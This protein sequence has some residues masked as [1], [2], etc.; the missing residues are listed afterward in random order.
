MLLISVVAGEYGR[1]FETRYLLNGLQTQSQR[2]FALL[3]AA[4]LEA[5]IAA[6]RPMLETVVTQAVRW[7]PDIVSVTMENEAGMPLVHWQ[8]PTEQPRLSLQSVSRDIAFAGDKVGHLTMAWNIAGQQAAIQ[9]H[10]TRMH[11]FSMSIFVLLTVS[12]RPACLLAGA[13]AP[14]QNQ[15]TPSHCGGGGTS[16]HRSRSRALR[17]SCGS[18]LPSMSWAVLLW[19]CARRRTRWKTRV[20]SGRRNSRTTLPSADVQQASPGRQSAQE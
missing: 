7:D 5:V 19:L 20:K 2:T 8:N 3:S 4:T 12:S 9:Q 13:P 11:I 15:S 10:A 6:D 14:A 1:A 18:A 17:S 16:P